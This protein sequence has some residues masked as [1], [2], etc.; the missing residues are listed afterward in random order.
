MG[1][2]APKWV[3][4]RGHCPPSG[5]DVVDAVGQRQ[6]AIS[7]KGAVA[8]T[9]A[10][11]GPMLGIRGHWRLP[12]ERRSHHEGGSAASRLSRRAS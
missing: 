5:L 10:M 1:D 6:V 7:E 3:P 4:L 12:G 8:S 11:H 9:D 2:L